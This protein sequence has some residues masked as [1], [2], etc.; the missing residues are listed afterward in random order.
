MVS[1]KDECIL[2]I[3]LWILIHSLLLEHTKYC[4]KMFV[5]ISKDHSQNMSNVE[6]IKKL[7][8]FSE[9]NQDKL[10]SPL[11]CFR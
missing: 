4:T 5:N 10:N 11:G 2:D 8:T 6:W 9:D 1:I 3:N 7:F